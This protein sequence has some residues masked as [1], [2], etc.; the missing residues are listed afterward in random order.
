MPN[1]NDQSIKSKLIHIAA[2]ILK[3]CPISRFEEDWTFSYHIGL[4]NRQFL[5]TQLNKLNSWQSDLAFK[6]KKIADSIGKD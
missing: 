3:D 4:R 2:E 5:Q 6:I 1:N